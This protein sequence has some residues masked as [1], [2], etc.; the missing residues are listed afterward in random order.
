MNTTDT[1][2]G[3][4]SG[5][6]HGAQN[7]KVARKEI[8]QSLTSTIKDYPGHQS[9]TSS[10]KWPRIPPVPNIRLS[11]TLKEAL[12]MIT[13]TL[14]S[15]GTHLTEILS[16]LEKRI[17][18]LNGIE[19]FS[20]EY[21]Y[22]CWKERMITYL[23]L[24]DEVNQTFR[25]WKMVSRAGHHI[26]LGINEHLFDLPVSR[27]AANVL[28][29]FDELLCRHG[30]GYKHL[31]VKFGE[32]VCNDPFIKDNH[33]L[34]DIMDLIDG[35]IP[36]LDDDQDELKS[37]DE[38]NGI[39]NVADGIDSNIDEI[40]NVTD[41]INSDTDGINDSDGIDDNIDGISDG[42]QSTNGK[43]SIISK[44]QCSSKMSDGV[45]SEFTPYRD[46][47]DLNQ[48][49]KTHC[50]CLVNVIVSKFYPHRDS[51]DLKLQP[52]NEYNDLPYRFSSEYIPHRDSF[53]LKRVTS[54]HQVV[55]FSYCMKFIPYQ[56]S[57]DKRSTI[58]SE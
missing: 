10:K 52:F 35:D 33:M 26:L 45:F 22:K 17:Q 19:C 18:M 40:E 49:S 15:H 58:A 1:A 38:I 8:R 31:V 54:D 21:S 14:P 30:D 6:Y 24:H 27:H 29:A 42:S 34:W 41:G 36:V 9:E 39:D 53:D 2:A 20:N 11:F 43:E 7:E 46:S 28:I 13:I 57:Y 56:D 16:S 55:P 3:N 25:V 47:Y 44:D 51:V 23:D 12:E 37:D 48:A 5:C 50:E 32:T 4:S